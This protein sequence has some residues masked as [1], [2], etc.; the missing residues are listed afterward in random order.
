M[1]YLG[2]FKIMSVEIEGAGD[3]VCVVVNGG[4]IRASVVGR[5]R[6]RTRGTKTEITM[7]DIVD[8]GSI[9]DSEGASKTHECR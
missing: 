5:A 7:H 6:Q 3:D 8:H 1:I 4:H 2:V 9:A